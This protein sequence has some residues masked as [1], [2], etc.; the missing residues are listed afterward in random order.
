M[1]NPRALGSLQPAGWGPVPGSLDEKPPVSGKQRPSPAHGVALMGGSSSLCPSGPGQRFC[2]TWGGPVAFPP[3][4]GVGPQILAVGLHCFSLPSTLPLANPHGRPHGFWERSPRSYDRYL[5]PPRPLTSAKDTRLSLEGT[6]GHSRT[7]ESC[8]AFQSEASM[9]SHPYALCV[10]D[11][12]SDQASHT[13][14]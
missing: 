3:G 9:W 5:C 2:R 13:P 1:S 6:W 10:Q 4:N 12:R 11:P 14:V 8:Y 7:T